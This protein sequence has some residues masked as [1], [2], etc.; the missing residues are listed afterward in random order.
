MVIAEKFYFYKRVQAVGESIVE[1]DAALRKLAIQCEFGAA[2]EESLRD[3]FVCGLQHQRT[4]QRLLPESGLTYQRALETAKAMETADTN[5]KSFNV[6]EPPIRNV[7]RKIP[8]FGKFLAL[9]QLWSEEPF[10]RGLSFQ[11]SHLL[12]MW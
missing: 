6:S 7:N 12:F 2:L 3:R 8:S 11:G 4:Q 9:P 5:T 1:F 10:P